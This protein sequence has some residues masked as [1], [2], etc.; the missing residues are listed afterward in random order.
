[1]AYTALE[2]MRENLQARYKEVEMGPCTPKKFE[3]IEGGKVNLITAVRH[4]IHE[5]CTDLRFDYEK[6]SDER[7]TGIFK[8]KSSREGQIPYNMQMDIDRLC[9][10]CAM[11][12]FWE[13]G[14]RE[15][16]FDVY[17]C[18]LEMFGM[19]YGS[20][21]RMI[22][23]LS[24]YET[25]A[26]TMLMSHRDHYSHSVYVFLLGLALF[27]SIPIVRN[28]Y[29]RFYDLK[30]DRTA[31]CHYLQ[32]WGMT[33]LF[34]DIGY[35][36]EISFE[37]VKSYFIQRNIEGG[38]IDGL[39]SLPFVCYGHMNEYVKLKESTV[40][41]LKEWYD[42][43]FETIEEWLAYAIARVLSRSDCPRVKG[44][45]MR[46]VTAALKEIARPTEEKKFLDHAYFSSIILFKELESVDQGAF[47]KREYLD[48]ITAIALHNSLYKR[49]LADDLAMR[50]D[51]HAF[52]LDWH[53]LAYLLQLTDELQCWDRISYGRNTKDELHAMACN[54]EFDEKGIYA[55]YVYDATENKKI[56]DYSAKYDLYVKNPEYVKKPKLKKYSEMIHDN[57]FAKEIG[58]IVALENQGSCKGD[59]RLEVSTKVDCMDSQKKQVYLSS[60]NFIHIYDFA[61]ALNAQYNKNFA[62]EKDILDDFEQLSL[63]YKLSNIGQAKNFAKALEQIGCFYTD[64]PVA[65]EMVTFFTPQ[66]LVCL[67]EYEH[68]RWENEKR[69]MYWIN[70]GVLASKLKENKNELR[71]LARMHYDLDVRY[72]DLSEVEKLKDTTQLNTMMEKLLEFDGIRVY[73]YK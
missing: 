73:R 42:T 51:D 50:L 67:G 15:D 34:H 31:A 13:S 38:N 41:K 10:A 57:P 55:E 17:F 28:E 44:K 22:E 2:E 30:D 54:M 6:D 25:T 40:A 59:I 5:T 12:R 37:Q 46:D 19:G 16:A 29:K 20:S 18:Y 33:A 7:E 62:S 60:S 64:R 3:K 32:F 53:P 47:L 39:E 61:A 48:A 72:E 66:E 43:D 49:I 14:S 52:M 24:E 56:T 23:L 69:G 4:F 11:E 35:P 70:G 8:G 65:Y 36:F 63:E 9:L 45:S 58:M 27:D 21:R 26:S 71:E 1:M 68:E